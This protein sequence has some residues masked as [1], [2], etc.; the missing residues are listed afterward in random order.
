LYSAEKFTAN[1]TDTGVI[2]LFRERE[3]ERETQNVG[4]FTSLPALNDNI[5]KKFVN[6]YKH[7][8]QHIKKYFWKI[9]LT[10]IL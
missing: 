3:R 5:Q 6:I 10:G 8:L 4:H 7:M 1:M 2:P 9:G